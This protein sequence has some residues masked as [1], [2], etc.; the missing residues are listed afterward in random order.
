MRY[1]AVT[2]ELSPP[3]GCVY[4]PLLL[5]AQVLRPDNAYTNVEIY[6]IYM[7]VRINLTTQ[8][9]KYNTGDNTFHCSVSGCIF[10]FNAAV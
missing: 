8:V 1:T 2:V 6:A 9:T 5:T 4:C 7:C 10:C 3:V